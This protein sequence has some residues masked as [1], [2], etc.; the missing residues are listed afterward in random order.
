MN[1][2][3]LN[4]TFTKTNSKNK[5]LDKSLLNN[6][7]DLLLSKIVNV[8]SI[9]LFIGIVVIIYIIFLNKKIINN[10]D[11]FSNETQTT[12]SVPLLN[13]TS[14]SENRDVSNR[15]PVTIYET[16]LKKLYGDNERL[17]C[18]IIPSV[19]NTTC[20]INNVSYVIY[21]F[22]VHMIKLPDSSILAVFN[23]GRLYKKTDLF[24]TMWA[25]PLKNSLP[26]D[27][28]PIR[29]VS[30]A[31]DLITLLCVGYDNK[32]YMKKPDAN[33]AINLTAPWQVV[34]NNTN[35][36]YILFD[37]ESGNMISIDINGKIFIKS[38]TDITS[39]NIELLNKLDRPILRLYYD[40]NGYMLV[41][42]TNFDL[43]QFSEL[44]WKNSSLN[45]YRGSNS[46]KL[47]DIL[48]HTDG[49]LVG[50]VFNPSSFMVQIMKQDQI[51]YLSN[52]T[53][54]ETHLKLNNTNEFVLSDLDIIKFKIGNIQI[55][56]NKQL[57]TNEADEDPNIAYQKQIIETRAD[58]KQY[59]SNRNVLSNTNYNNYE[60]L[61]NVEKNDD[62]IIKLKDIV[63]KLI[64]YEPDKEKIIDKYPIIKSNNKIQ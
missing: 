16:S 31:C 5:S 42:D 3:I 1:K 20:T 56:I 41:I 39:D 7:K 35:I 25:G 34:P 11:N 32:L 18:S 15:N 24:N 63:N 52:F 23:D 48:Y 29:I 50:L 40:L 38:S 12:N 47:N 33:G 60:L 4:D 53:P 14:L 19:G 55:Y 58:I 44:N 2:H 26:N 21:N 28:I 45:L 43:Y 61:A 27:N 10:F 51:F 30:I 59:C 46:S 62:K 9:I 36:I 13:T 54:F 22:P 17:I 57:D 6:N 8:G 64:T 49:K 37:S